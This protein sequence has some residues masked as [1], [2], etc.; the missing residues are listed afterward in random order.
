M[1]LKVLEERKHWLVIYISYHFKMTR[2]HITETKKSINSIF[3]MGNE[4]W[5]DF[6]LT[7]PVVIFKYCNIDLYEKLCGLLQNNSVHL[8]T[9]FYFYSV[10]IAAINRFINRSLLM[11]I[12]LLVNILAIFSRHGR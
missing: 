6:Y 3:L 12:S 10:K 9:Q 11:L 2:T 1:K 4:P 8:S 7:V 5:L